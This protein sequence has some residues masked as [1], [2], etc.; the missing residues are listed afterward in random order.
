MDDRP[1]N[2][3]EDRRR[4]GPLGDEE[5][6]QEATRRVPQARDDDATR[7]IPPEDDERETTRTPDSERTSPGTPR[8]EDPETRVIRTPGAHEDEPYPRSYMEAV[9][10]REARLK[11]VYGGVDWLAS[12]IGG[13]FALVC[14]G[15]L[16]SLSGLV[17][18]RLGFTLDLANR[19]IDAAIITGL[20]IVGLV[21]FLAYFCGGYV[22]G[23]LARFDGGR[24]G[25]A[26]VLWGVLLSFIFALFGSLLPGAFFQG[27]QDVVVTN[28][29][30]AVSSLSGAGL[31][32]AGI[33]AGALILELLGGFL[34]G[35]LGNSYHARIDYTT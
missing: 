33:I 7:R 27:L 30:P 26:T 32:G 22:S 25:L 9:D 2:E 24:N 15:I 8:E 31:T 17:L 21:L 20:V 29:V 34:G 14:T 10:Q 5:D 13:V 4:R 35:R 19:E 1:Q 16:L 3:T 6:A 23:R 28:V 11:E 18:T 12:F